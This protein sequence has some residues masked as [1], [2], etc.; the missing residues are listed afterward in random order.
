MF[1]SVWQLNRGNWADA[2][3]AI[4][5]ALAQIDPQL[6][7]LNNHAAMLIMVWAKLFEGSLQEAGSLLSDL[8]GSFSF[9]QRGAITR[10]TLQ[11]MVVF[12]SLHGDHRAAELA[13][14]KIKQSTGQ[15]NS[16]AV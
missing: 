10:W 4:A 2:N 11:T 8:E 3:A 12:H 1:D 13:V 6:Q 15:N 14:E 5:T 16:N 9:A 7:V